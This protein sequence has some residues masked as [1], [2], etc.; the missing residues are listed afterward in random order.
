MDSVTI[1][2][3]GMHTLLQPAELEPC[4]GVINGHIQRQ[5]QRFR[6]THGL[7]EQKPALKGGKHRL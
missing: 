4:R 5:L 1:D 3:S 7:R 2:N 6:R